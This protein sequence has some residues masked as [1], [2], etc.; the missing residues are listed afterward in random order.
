[1]SYQAGIVGIAIAVLASGCGRQEP[2]S[3]P[4]AAPAQTVRVASVNARER[5]ATEEVV[6]T[7]RARLRAV[8]ESKVTGKL[9]SMRVVPGQAVAAGELVAELDVKEIRARW[10]QSR[11]VREQAEADLKRFTSLWEQK[12]LSQAEFDTAQSRFRVADSAAIEAEAL[13]SYA[14]VTAPFAGVITRK[15]ADV[16]DLATPGRALAEIEDASSLRLEADIPEAVI[17]RIRLGDSLPVRIAALETNLTGIVSEIAPSA[18]A[19]SHT[20][21]VKL[22]LPPL[23]GLRA[24]QFGRVAVPVGAVRALRIPAS[25]LI[26]RGQMELVFVVRDQAAHLRLVKTGKRI[27]DEVEILSGLDPDEVVVVDGVAQLAD[28]QKVEVR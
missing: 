7:V 20:F 3:S 6:G 12:I 11:A 5:V 13:L 17:G 8:I 4:P 28:G 1:M 18:D 2:V 24:G 22:D 16:G 27:A 9:E 19:G 21:L 23:P 14:R 15:L 25:A 10:D 26:V